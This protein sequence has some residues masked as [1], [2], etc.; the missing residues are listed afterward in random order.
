[1]TCSL[2]RLS[3]TVECQRCNV[4]DREEGWRGEGGFP[5]DMSEVQEVL[6]LRRSQ[7]GGR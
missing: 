5:R 2:L 7:G 4:V 1:M 6:V 3:V